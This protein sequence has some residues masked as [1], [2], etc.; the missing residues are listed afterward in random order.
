MSSQALTGFL[1]LALM[2]GQPEDE[3]SANSLLCDRSFS[4]SGK[5]LANSCYGRRRS[6]S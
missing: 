2:S 4:K 5:E 1:G 6:P 3:K